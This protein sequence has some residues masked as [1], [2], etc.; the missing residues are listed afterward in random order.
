MWWSPRSPC[1][2]PRN[3]PPDPAPGAPS[4]CVRP[5]LRRG[6][7]PDARRPMPDGTRCFRRSPT[8]A[9]EQ[10]TGSNSRECPASP[11]LTTSHDL[12]TRDAPFPTGSNIRRTG[13]VG[14]SR[15]G[16]RG[17]N[18]SYRSAANTVNVDGEGNPSE[19]T[20]NTRVCLALPAQPPTV[21][22]E[23]VSTRRG[24]GPKKIRLQAGGPSDSAPARSSPS[25]ASSSRMRIPTPTTMKLSARLKSGHE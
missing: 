25:L 7:T 11:S 19:R 2:P 18:A 23:S 6:L 22:G 10:Q 12:A 17:C 14:R 20:P 16:E 9:R 21:N 4:V 5:A 3:P 13:S 1:P 24:R 15:E 8:E